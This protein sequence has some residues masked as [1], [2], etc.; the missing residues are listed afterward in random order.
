MACI[1]ELAT[2]IPSAPRHIALMKS[3]GV[4]IPPVISHDLCVVSCFDRQCGLIA[5]RHSVTC[6]E[7][8]TVQ[9]NF[10]SKNLKP[11]MS[12]FIQYVRYKFP[13]IYQS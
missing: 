3:D 12:V 6:I 2:A 4:R 7:V 5:H 8:V 10:P 13:G 9:C 1:A 11:R